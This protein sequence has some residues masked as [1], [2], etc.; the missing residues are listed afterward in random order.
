MKWTFVKLVLFAL[1]LVLSFGFGFAWRDVRA[2]EAPS[3]DAFARLV[4]S[5]DALAS[6]T[7]TQLFKQEFDRILENYYRPIDRE[8]LTYAA[9]RGL[10]SSLGD[11]HTEFLEPIVASEFSKDT[12]GENNFVGV[13]A[14]L[15]PDPLGAKI[16]SVFKGGPAFNGGAKNGDLIV[17]IDGVSVTG[18]PVDEI[19]SKIRG[20]RG[21][22]VKLTVLRGGSDEPIEL[23]MTRDTIVVPTVDARMLGATSTGLITVTQFSEPTAYQFDEAVRELENQGMDGLIIDLRGNP[24]GLLE[25]AVEMLSRFVDNKPVVK[26]RGKGGREQIARTFGGQRRAWDYPIAILINGDSASASEIFAGVL[27]EYK[28]ATLVGEHSYGKASVQTVVSLQGDSSAKIT[29]ARYYLPSGADISRKV[30]EDGEY[31]S[32]GIIPDIEEELD[33]STR[34]VMG[35]PDR[36]N[37]LRKAMEF[38]SSQR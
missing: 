20:Q 36:D 14:R 21:T 5:K 4:G 2:G 7:P 18:T 28:M 10:M 27:S 3:G 6:L 25:T 9:M 8:Q 31:V 33:L 37:Q 22:T 29:I 19:V 34:T 24:G 1:L 13:G 30:D 15:A 38:I 16:M 35:D 11:P 32:G 12:R 17:A 26:M 23:T